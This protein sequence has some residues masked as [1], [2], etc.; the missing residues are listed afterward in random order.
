MV[1]EWYR[2]NLPAP[3]LSSDQFGSLP[4]SSATH[5]PGTERQLSHSLWHRTAGSTPGQHGSPSS[6]CQPGT[7]VPE[8]TDGESPAGHSRH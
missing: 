8:S 3:P 2:I 5:Q 6:D 4:S 1:E 7:D